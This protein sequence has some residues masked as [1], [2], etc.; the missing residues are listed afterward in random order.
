MQGNQQT[1]QPFFPSRTKPFVYFAV[2]IV[3]LGQSNKALNSLPAVAGISRYAAH[4]LVR[5]YV[6]EAEIYKT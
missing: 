1:E 6:S 2:P 3:T 5:R 4:P